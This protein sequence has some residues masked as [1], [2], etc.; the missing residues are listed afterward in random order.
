M[1][2]SLPAF[3]N[4]DLRWKHGLTVAKPDVTILAID[5]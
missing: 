1:T 2:Y 4:I 3:C 5:R